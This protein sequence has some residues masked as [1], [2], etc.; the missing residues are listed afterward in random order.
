MQNQNY[1]CNAIYNTK[2]NEILSIAIHLTNYVQYLLVYIENYK[3]LIKEHVED[4]SKW[5]NKLC[6]WI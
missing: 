5:K 3:L 6:S 2:E 4:L 1:K